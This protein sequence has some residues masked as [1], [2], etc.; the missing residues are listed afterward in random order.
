M[1]G[2]TED[3]KHKIM[4]LANEY[5]FWSE[6]YAHSNPYSDAAKRALMHRNLARLELEEYLQSLVK[7]T[8]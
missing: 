2:L 7:E 6:C 5:A 8:K 4:L 3:T 1:T